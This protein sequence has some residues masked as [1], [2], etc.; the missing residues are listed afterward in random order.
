MQHGDTSA[1]LTVR[2]IA[3][4]AGTLSDA[5]GNTMSNFTPGTHLAANSAL[6]VVTTTTPTASS[7]EFTWPAADDGND[8]ASGTVDEYDLSYTSEQIAWADDTGGKV[9]AQVQWRVCNLIIDSRLLKIPGIFVDAIVF[10]KIALQ[11]SKQISQGTTSH[12]TTGG[13]YDH[14][15]KNYCNL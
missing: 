4:S 5:A 8:S 6:V 2:S 10:V 7:V 11:L 1:D 15:G 9:I 3:L 13:S 12:P 14:K